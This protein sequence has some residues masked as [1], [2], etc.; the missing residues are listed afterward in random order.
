MLDENGAPNRPGGCNTCYGAIEIKSSD[1]KTLDK[2]SHYYLISH[3]SKVIHPGAVRIDVI[4]DKKVEGVY[5]TAAENLDGSEVIVLQN[6]T[7]TQKI[8]TVKQG[9]QLFQCVLPEKSI[10][11]CKW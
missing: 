8:I 9:K 1:Y 6:D 7:E 10:V 5:F 4:P 2:K 3:L 11:S